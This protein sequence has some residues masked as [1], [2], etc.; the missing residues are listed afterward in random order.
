MLPRPRRTHDQPLRAIWIAGIGGLVIGHI[1]WLAA[2]SLAINTSTVNAWVLV[3]AG[4]SLAGGAVSAWYGWR[5]Y[6]RKS[7]VW[8]AFRLALPVSPVLF[9]LVVLG[10]TYL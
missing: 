10:V 4:L 9:S 1:L 3:V 5:C 6:Q 7:D 2:I 8:A